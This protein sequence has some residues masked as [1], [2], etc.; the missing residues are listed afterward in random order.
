MKKSTIYL[1][2]ELKAGVERIAQAENRSEAD[3]IRD[4]IARA[5]GER[6]APAPRIPLAPA[7]GNP[8][9]AERAEEL[10]DGFGK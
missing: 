2:N 9:V 7:L 5:I 8:D 10:L 6:E 3:V 4:A 1:P